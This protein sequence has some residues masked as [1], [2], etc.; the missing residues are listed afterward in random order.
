MD[1]INF[2]PNKYI[3]VYLFRKQTQFKWN[4]F[5]YAEKELKVR[6]SN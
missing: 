2:V 5:E 1:Y 3:C 6:C 4:K